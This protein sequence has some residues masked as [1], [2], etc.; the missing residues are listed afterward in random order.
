[1]GGSK[2]G[3]APKWYK[4]PVG[5]RFSGLGELA[6]FKENNTN[7]N[8]YGAAADDTLGVFSGFNKFMDADSSQ[9]RIE[10]EMDSNPEIWSLL[11]ATLKGDTAEYLQT[12]GFSPSEIT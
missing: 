2:E 12:F 9:D 6:T 10:L 7:I 8:L 1:M 11:K 3:Y 4:P 5:G